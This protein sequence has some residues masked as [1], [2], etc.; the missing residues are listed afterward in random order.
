MSLLAPLYALG[1]LA[2]SLPLIFHLIQ[3]RPQG[4]MSFSSLMFLSPTP[5]RL[6]RRSRLDNLLLL[7]LRGLALLLLSLA[8]ARPFLRA[9]EQLNL[10][11]PARRIVLA[12]V[13]GEHSESLV[14]GGLWFISGP[15]NANGASARNAAAFGH[16]LVALRK[17]RRRSLQ[18]AETP[19][20]RTR[21]TSP[22]SRPPTPSSGRSIQR[23]CFTGSPR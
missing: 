20:E 9:V 5:P 15:S 22:A 14:F 23:P 17:D 1:A 11:T 3:R 16:P 2:I 18:S 7:F 4:E 12:V 10:E 6:T 8:F 19:W 21:T 13:W